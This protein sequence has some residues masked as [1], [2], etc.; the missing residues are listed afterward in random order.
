MCEKMKEELGLFI[1]NKGPQECDT[2]LLNMW[3]GECHM[4]L[5]QVVGQVA[6]RMMSSWCHPV[7]PIEFDD[8]IQSPK[9]T[10]LLMSLGLTS[11]AT[12]H[13]RADMAPPHVAT[14]QL[15]CGLPAKFRSWPIF[16]SQTDF[17]WPNQKRS[18][19]CVFQLDKILFSPNLLWGFQILG[20]S[21][22]NCER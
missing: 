6:S 7:A 19:T 16:N 9:M 12:T 10:W 17:N 5:T 1:R 3:R 13:A 4:A 15:N 14:W 2:H 20:I 18:R 22:P 21:W 11:T 8:V